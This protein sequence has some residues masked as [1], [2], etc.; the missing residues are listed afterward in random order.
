[1]IGK[2]FRASNSKK[3][4]EIQRTNGPTRF[5][6]K[7]RVSRRSKPTKTEILGCGCSQYMLTVF[8]G[9]KERLEKLLAVTIGPMR[10]KSKHIKQS[11]YLRVP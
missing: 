6:A 8:T 5:P 3:V 2:M 4:T 11:L 7:E 10:H 9:V 1:M